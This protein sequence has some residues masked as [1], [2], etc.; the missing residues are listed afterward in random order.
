MRNNFP[1]LNDA[2]GLF[3]ATANTCNTS[4]ATQCNTKPT[5]LSPLSQ[6][7]FSQKVAQRSLEIPEITGKFGQDW[8]LPL[9][10]Q[11]SERMDERTPHVHLTLPQHSKAIGNILRHSTEMLSHLGEKA[12]QTHSY[13]M[14]P[15]GKHLSTKQTFPRENKKKQQPS[16]PVTLNLELWG[17]HLFLTIIHI[18]M[19][20]CPPKSG[21]IAFKN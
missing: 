6:K 11:V 13:T 2:L 20:D 12:D 1:Y 19:S 17:L 16:H 21:L 8:V 5:R 7:S 14:F 10:F 18:S 15:N 4:S 9:L 3:T